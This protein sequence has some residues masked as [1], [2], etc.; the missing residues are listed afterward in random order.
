MKSLFRRWTP[1]SLRGRITAVYLVALVVTL[2][3]FGVV[4]SLLFVSDLRQG[5]TD[6]VTARVGDLAAAV[7]AGDLT[8]V[9]QDPYAQVI[10]GRKVTVRSSAAP[11]SPVLDDAELTAARQEKLVVHKNVPGLGDDAVLVATPLPGGKVAVAGA[12][13]DTVNTAARRLITGLAL[14]LPILLLLLTLG[15]RRLLG[16]A[17]R[18]VAGLTAEAQEISTA[19][20]GRR[21]PVPPGEDEIA[22]LARTLNGMLDRIAAATKRERTFLDAAAHELRTPVATLRA[23][24]ELGLAG[25]EEQAQEALRGALREADRLARLTA[26][27]LTLARAR[28]GQLPLERMPTDVTDRVREIARRV[29]GVYPLSV[30]VVGEELVGDVD[31]V[32]LDQVVTNLVANAAQ[33]GASQVTVGVRGEPPATVVITV[34]DD[35][36]GFPAAML[37]VQFPEPGSVPR[38]DSSGTGLGLTIVDMIARAHSG[39]VL[40]A[41]TSP[42]GGA[43]VEVRL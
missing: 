18:P 39:S 21:L 9:E 33:A 1:G 28:A 3:G 23:E 15:V 4:G 34:D 31:P 43:H 22:S 37:P 36:P 35:G 26:D 29:A 7:R 41:N 17:L 10:D 30:R 40:A 19:D 5:D 38:H 20:P 12:S 27:M 2:T 6:E 25:G 8:P 24:L 11:D 13:L 42:L 32:R 16:S 14:G